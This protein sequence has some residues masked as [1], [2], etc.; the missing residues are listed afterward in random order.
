MKAVLKYIK[1]ITLSVAIIFIS[2][3]VLVFLS[4]W[5]LG[6]FTDW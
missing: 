6:T 3:Y 1:A 4:A 5:Y 2:I